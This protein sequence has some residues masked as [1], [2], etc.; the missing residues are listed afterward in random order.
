MESAIKESINAQIKAIASYR[1][2]LMISNKPRFDDRLL[3]QLIELEGTYLELKI[4]NKEND[5]IDDIKFDLCKKYI[6]NRTEKKS[7]KSIL[8]KL[9]NFYI[10]HEIN[11]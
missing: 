5:K 6:K 11:I 4:F 9:E 7:N 3:S 8:K 10:F 2:L 1:K